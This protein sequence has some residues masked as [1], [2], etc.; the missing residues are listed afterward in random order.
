[1]EQVNTPEDTQ[2]GIHLEASPV[3]VPTDQRED[4]TLQQSQLP[5]AAWVF[6]QA[7]VTSSLSAS[8]KRKMSVIKFCKKIGVFYVAL[9]SY[10]YCHVTQMTRT[11]ITYYCS[12]VTRCQLCC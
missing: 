2:K 1:M 3:G 7:V 11:I 8:S 4:Q 6:E 5:W 12:L 10:C 9:V